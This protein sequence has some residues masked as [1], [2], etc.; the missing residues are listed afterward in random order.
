MYEGEES[1][2][3]VSIRRKQGGNRRKQ[4]ETGEEWTTSVQR[5]KSN[6][7]DVLSKSLSATTNTAG[8]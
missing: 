5:G 2:K 7:R 8:E 6:S 4:E 1:V 3:A